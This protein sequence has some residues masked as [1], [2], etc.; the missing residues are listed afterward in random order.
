M[1]RL[2]WR[3]PGEPPVER[4]PPHLWESSLPSRIEP[5]KEKEA[6]KLAAK[7]AGESCAWLKTAA[8][9]PRCAKYT[10]GAAT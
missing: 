4:R 5:G 3:L 10:H 6:R 2:M 1:G 8:V 9:R 7:T